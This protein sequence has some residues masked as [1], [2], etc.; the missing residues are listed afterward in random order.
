M[1]H[2]PLSLSLMEY[3]RA[4][5]AGIVLPDLRLIVE[6]LHRTGW[7]RE[8]ILVAIGDAAD[9]QLCDITDD[10]PTRFID[11]PAPAHTAR[12][13]PARLPRKVPS[14]DLPVEG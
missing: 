12:R 5:C 8:E 2:T 11:N 14:S 3:R 1:F 9:R 4:Q 6:K 10:C 7:S 13:E